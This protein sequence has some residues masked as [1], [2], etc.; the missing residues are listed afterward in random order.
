MRF[1]WPFCHKVKNCHKK[2]PIINNLKVNH[3]DKLVEVRAKK[4]R[5]LRVCIRKRREIVIL[6]SFAIPT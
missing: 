5:L 2:K 3:N 1:D 6:L 4:L